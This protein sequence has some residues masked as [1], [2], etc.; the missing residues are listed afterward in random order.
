M[1]VVTDAQMKQMRRQITM[2]GFFPAVTLPIC[3]Y[4]HHCKQCNEF[5][6][7]FL[8]SHYKYTLTEMRNHYA[9]GGQL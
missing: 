6:E 4:V 7:C 3:V 5:S 1:K 9:H 2:T 8:V